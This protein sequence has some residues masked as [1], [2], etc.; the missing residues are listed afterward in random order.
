MPERPVSS[1]L[2]FLGVISLIVGFF[3]TLAGSQ[4]IKV[5]KVCVEPGS[6]TWGVGPAYWLLV[7]AS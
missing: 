3:L 1:V 4:I 2:G 7:Q 6:R 5:E